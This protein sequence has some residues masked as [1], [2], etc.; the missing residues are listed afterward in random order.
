MN[1]FVTGDQDGTVQLIQ[2]ASSLDNA[3]PFERELRALIGAA[4]E[5]LEAAKIFISE[6]PPPRGAI[7]PHDVKWLPA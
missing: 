3:A 5:F 7:V 2:V 1:D 6:T 4:P